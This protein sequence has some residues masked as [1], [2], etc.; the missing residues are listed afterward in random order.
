MYKLIIILSI[1]AGLFCNLSAEVYSISNSDLTV[2]VDEVTGKY[3]IGDSSG[4]ALINGFPN[5]FNTHFI[6]SL[7]DS[8][9]SNSDSFTNM[10]TLIPGSISEN[11]GIIQSV[12][13]IGS[14]EI[15]QIIEF[16]DFN[17]SH[18][19]ALKYEIHNQ[20]QIIHDIGIAHFYAPQVPGTGTRSFWGNGEQ[21]SSTYQL[22]GHLIPQLIQIYENDDII[23]DGTIFQTITNG[24]E[25]TT[26]GLM[27]FGN[28]DSLSNIEWDMETDLVVPITSPALFTRWNVDTYNVNEQM[29]FCQYIGLGNVTTHNGEFDLSV[30]ALDN[31]EQNFEEIL[32]SSVTVQFFA[33]NNHNLA[34]DSMYAVMELSQNLRF[35]NSTAMQTMSPDSISTGE[36]SGCKWTINASNPQQNSQEEVTITLYSTIDTVSITRTIDV[37]RIINTNF[38]QDF[39]S[40]RFPPKWWILDN[41]HNSFTWQSGNVPGYSF[42]EID[43]FNI[44]S[45]YCPYVDVDDYQ[46]EWLISQTLVIDE[47]LNG[48]LE[49]YTCY[50]S[51]YMSTS[52]YTV[53]ITTDDGNNWTEVW[54]AEEDNIQ[55][56]DWE[57]V[58]IDLTAYTGEHIRI[59]WH[60]TGYN[61]DIV[62]LDGIILD[63]ARDNDDVTVKSIDEVYNY[64]NPFNPQTTISFS[65]AEEQVVDVSVYNLKGQKV[66]N[67]LNKQL[68]KGNHEIVWNGKDKNGNNAGSGVYFY[69]IAPEKGESILKKCIMLK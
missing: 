12:Y 56:L 25:A 24:I 29:N 49:F 48:Y 7:D 69:K 36:L 20:D 33:R 18:F 3:N 47:R 66:K 13:N 28:S 9:Y 35:A 21:I 41:T 39:D 11:N 43:P 68:R 22:S 55:S 67:L 23:T 58:A 38:R 19:A 17:N 26:P 27:I 37:P 14:V 42:S 10:T 53:E 5:S 45:A 2:N 6:V 54:H 8:Y 46:D 30:S 51:G 57:A 1:A 31:F 62:I 44:Y 34:A 65:V 40:V 60:N 32:P 52:D 15:K 63:G 61:N 50:N 59:G 16:Q 64:P 4:N